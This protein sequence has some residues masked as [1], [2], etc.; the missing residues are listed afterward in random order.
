MQDIQDHE[1]CYDFVVKCDSDLNTPASI[2]RNELRC[3]IAI[4][5]TPLAEY[6]VLGFLCVGLNVQITEELITANS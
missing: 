3:S 4:H 6:V 5:G 1:G 2:M